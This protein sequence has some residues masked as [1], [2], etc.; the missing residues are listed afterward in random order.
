MNIETALNACKDF[1][2]HSKKTGFRMISFYGGEPTLNFE[3]IEKIVL[4]YEQEKGL[5]F[6]VSTNGTKLKDYAKFIQDHRIF[7]AVSLDGPKGIHDKNRVSKEKKGSYDEI[8]KGLNAL[9]DSFKKHHLSFSATIKDPEDFMSC[10]EFFS[11]NFQ[12]NAFRVG[13]VKF[14]DSPKKEVMATR[15]DFERLKNIYLQMVTN[16][17]KIPT[18]LSFLFEEGLNLI[19]NRVRNY[20]EEELSCLHSCIPGVRKLFITTEGKYY[21]C[22]KLAYPE[23]EIG[24]NKQGIDRDKVLGLLKFV[25]DKENDYCSTCWAG[26]IC[27]SCILLESRKE[28]KYDQER[29]CQNCDKKR[30]SIIDYLSL[31]ADLKKVKKNE[32]R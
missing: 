12:N 18:F 3:L 6:S 9:D 8:M 22:E 10:F 17:N 5:G 31:Y 11:N 21:P 24:D 25:I 15:K 16:N 19:D 14:L 13:F 7:V 26:T 30:N 4:T 29:L 20:N 1:L 32:R 23:L 27:N 28:G 2:D